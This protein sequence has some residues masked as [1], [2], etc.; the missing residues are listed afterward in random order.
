[1][2][3]GPVRVPSNAGHG[4]ANVTLSM[5][6]WPEGNVQPGSF[7]A[8]IIGQAIDTPGL[9]TA[10]TSAKPIVGREI[11]RAISRFGPINKSN[12]ELLIEQTKAKS[13]LVRRDAIATLAKF[14][15]QRELIE[16]ALLALAND[17]TAIVRADALRTLA[18]MEF[19]DDATVPAFIKAI[20]DQSYEVRRTAA[21]ELSKRL[22]KDRTGRHDV[23]LALVG[24][25]RDKD[26]YVRRYAAQGIGL[27]EDKVATTFPA[28]TKLLQDAD[29]QVRSYAAAAIVKNHSPKIDELL[30]GLG[31]S[32]ADSKM[33]IAVA[34]LREQG[35]RITFSAGVPT[36]LRL[37]DKPDL[38]AHDLRY[39]SELTEL[40]SM[41][42]NSTPVGNDIVAQIIDLPKLEYIVLWNAGLTDE[43]VERLSQKSSIK[44]LGVGANKITDASMPHIKQMSQLTFLSLGDTQIT[45]DGLKE[46]ANLTNLTFLG[47][48]ATHVT[49]DGL[50]HL[51]KLTNLTRLNIFRGKIT[52][53]GLRHI[54]HLDKLRV[55]DIHETAVDDSAVEHIS[56]LEGLNVVYARKTQITP[57]GASQ[58]RRAVPQCK[59]SLQ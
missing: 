29:S 17:P 50:V 8:L 27:A 47:I 2:F 24:A 51:Q 11:I 56:M 13:L 9:A 58:I 23:M 32:K 1:M 40:K 26:I 36:K 43:A 5:P 52:S 25:L 18:R 53:A 39:V 45:N 59:L 57:D 35:A 16:T 6:G 37:D 28:L 33:L 12:A 31:N 15:E 55:L 34:A 10:L 7:N 46:I 49:D 48:A 38:N 54:T 19:V 3:C 42:I 14:K 21:Y 20:S 22:T 41:T 30:A 44:Q 4:F